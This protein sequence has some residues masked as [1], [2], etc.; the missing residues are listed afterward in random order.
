MQIEQQL[1]LQTTSS[2]RTTVS[3]SVC[4]Y[5]DLHIYKLPSY[6]IPWKPAESRST[7]LIC[8]GNTSWPSLHCWLIKKKQKEKIN[9]RKIKNHKTRKRRS[10][11]GLIKSHVSFKRKDDLMCSKKISDLWTYLCH[12]DF[13]R[14]SYKMDQLH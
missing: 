13:E 2:Q 4:R 14:P 1:H 8:S 5:D 11:G 7:A 9:L 12:S 10:L 6:I 3:A